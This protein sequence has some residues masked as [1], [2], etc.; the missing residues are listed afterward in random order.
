MAHPQPTTRQPDPE[1]DPVSASISAYVGRSVHVIDGHADYMDA[2]RQR[3]QLF[4]A[5]IEANTVLG[6]VGEHLWVVCV[7]VH[8]YRRARRT[9]VEAR[10]GD[11]QP[12]R[13]TRSP[14]P[15]MPDGGEAVEM[16][17]GPEPPAP[18]TER[19]G[20]KNRGHQLHATLGASG[21]EDHHE[22][23]SRVL[24]RRTTSFRGISAEDFAAVLNSLTT[25]R[26][27]LHSR[28]VA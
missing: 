1:S 6:V 12:E 16:E 17:T 22:Y 24:G 11:R 25:Q 26:R 27:A 5:G 13:I 9:L 19:R 28:K 4:S 18:R 20:Y 3:G 10:A 21:I 14:E 2:E 8:E 7:P 15:A 23:A